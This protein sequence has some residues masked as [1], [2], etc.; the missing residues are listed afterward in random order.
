MGRMREIPRCL[1]RLYIFL[2]FS[3]V[4]FVVI[5]AYKTDIVLT[6]LLY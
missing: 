3:F 6:L 5:N 4:L 1:F 2:T